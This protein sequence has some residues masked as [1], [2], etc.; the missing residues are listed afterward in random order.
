MNK[1][2]ASRRVGRGAMVGVF[3]A[4]ADRRKHDF[5]IAA[6]PNR[7]LGA[8]QGDAADRPQAATA[9]AGSRFQSC[10]IIP[11]ITNGIGRRFMAKCQVTR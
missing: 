9:N 11:I 3:D 2:A 4:I 10:F 8:G 6:D 7:A 5:A 1:V